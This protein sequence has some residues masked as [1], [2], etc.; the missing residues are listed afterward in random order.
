MDVALETGKR[1]SRLVIEAENRLGELLSNN[2]PGFS[3][4]NSGQ[5]K[6]NPLAKNIE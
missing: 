1:V 2:P 4:G 6:Q 3:R 5:I